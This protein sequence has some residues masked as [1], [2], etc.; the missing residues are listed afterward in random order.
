[1]PPSKP[2]WYAAYTRCKSEKK[3]AFELARQG[4]EH[5]LPLQTTIRQWSDRKKKVQVPL[6]RSYVFVR[7]TLKEYLAVLQIPWVVNIVH[8]SGKPVPVPDW[9]IDNL[10]ILLGAGIPIQ[11]KFH[12]LEKGQEVCINQGPLQGLRG[13]II[14]V[15]RRH[16]FAIRIHALNYNLTIDIDPGFVEK[17]TE[18]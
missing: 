1:M 6:I 11:R 5:Y 16:M 9:Q 3:V 2:F 4:I 17:V 10:K 13:T 12:E 18:K 7:I 15:R 8:F 14:S